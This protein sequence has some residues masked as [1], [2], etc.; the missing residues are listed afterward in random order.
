MGPEARI[1][2]NIRKAVHANSGMWIKQTGQ[3]GM[4]DRLCILPGGRYIFVEL[5][6]ARGSPT[7]LQRLMLRRL[8]ALG[9]DVRLVRGE[10]EAE[11]FIAEIERTARKEVM[12]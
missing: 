11:Q 5:K 8:G 12:Q 1:E 4:P 10:K 6:A 2:Q 7:P 9:C 3:D